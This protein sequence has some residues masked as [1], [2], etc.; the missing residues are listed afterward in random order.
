MGGKAAAL[1]NSLD[2]AVYPTEPK[3]AFFVSLAFGQVPD[4]KVEL[5][6]RGLRVSGNKAELLARLEEALQ[7]P[8]V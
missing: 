1:T 7:Q 2:A 5:R 8:A 3:T 6:G 4:L